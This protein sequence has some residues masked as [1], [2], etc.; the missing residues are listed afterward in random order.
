M[1]YFTEEFVTGGTHIDMSQ[2]KE[3][4][5]VGALMKY[6][7]ERKIFW[8]RIGIGGSITAAPLIYNNTCLLYTSP[9]PRD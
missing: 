4:E 3:V 7:A 1:K 6:K 8:D 2:F 5:L 9:S